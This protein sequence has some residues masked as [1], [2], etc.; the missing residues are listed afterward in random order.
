MTA[1]PESGEGSLMV[2]QSTAGS[3]TDWHDHAWRRSD[4]GLTTST[5]DYRCDLCSLTWSGYRP[6]LDAHGQS[7]LRRG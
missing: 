4:T 1:T 7:V 5:Y 6:T 2:E 3:P